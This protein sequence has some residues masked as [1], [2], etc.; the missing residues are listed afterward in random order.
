MLSLGFSESPNRQG[1]AK[2]M[3]AWKCLS[4]LNRGAG[5]KALVDTMPP[6]FGWGDQSSPA[7]KI[8]YS[9][10]YLSLGTRDR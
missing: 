2:G 5:L 10:T 9:L 3:W 1:W 6:F 4:L 8:P 7:R